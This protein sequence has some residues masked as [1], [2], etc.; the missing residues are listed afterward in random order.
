MSAYS[1]VVTTG[2]YCRPGCPAR[3]LPA[4]VRPFDLPAAAEASGYRACLRCRPYR[5]PAA[6]ELAAPELVCRAV[7][8]IADGALDGATEAELGSRLGVSARHLRRLFAE[9][10]GVTP[11][12]LA[13]SRRAHF[14]RRLLDDTDLAIT[15]IAFASGFGSVRQLNRACHDVF[16]ASP[17]ALRARRRRTDRLVADGGLVLR[18]PYRGPL[19]WDAML[20]YASTRAIPHVEDVRDGVYRR[21]IVVDDEPGVLE[22][23]A[24]GADHLVLRAHLPYWDGLIHVVERA[25]RIFGLDAPV[26]EAVRDLSGDPVL[27]PLVAARPGLRV[28]G[29][30]DPFEL[31]V[32]AI[33]GQQVSVSGATTLVG[34]LVE[35]LG[36]PVPGLQ[37][38]GLTHA[39]PMP[40]AVA[41]GDLSRLGLTGARAA[42]VQAFASAVDSG[43]VRLDRS[44]SLDELVAS[45]VAVRGVGPWTAHYIALRLGERDAFPAGDLG[46]RR[47][48][49]RLA[50]TAGGPLEEV[51][52]AWSPWRANAAVHL[53]LAP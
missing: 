3:P 21:T 28:P 42:A 1:A 5:S 47:S 45:L 44:A 9:H 23:A 24:G 7:Q 14:A 15:D 48:L 6:V 39:F 26:D 46:L 49:A 20:A 12:Q 2:I 30:W 4:N 53:W 11:D 17:G 37:P 27:G 32:R 18:L 33:L 31:G 29:T 51:A 34:R 41:A 25:R 22:I 52:R 38:L 8:M 40:K 36:R 16:R 35:R 13:R 43:D 10:I 50:P 19:A